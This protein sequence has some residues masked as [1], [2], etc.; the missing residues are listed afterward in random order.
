MVKILFTK[1]RLW[2]FCS[3]DACDAKVVSERLSSAWGERHEP[4]GKL[5]GGRTLAGRTGRDRLELALRQVGVLLGLVE[6]G[7]WVACIGLAG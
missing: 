2:A 6:D 4:R 7:E 3:A 1:E 5:P